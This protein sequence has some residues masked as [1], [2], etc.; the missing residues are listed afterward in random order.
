VIGAKKVTAPDGTVWRVGRQWVPTKPT[1]WRPKKRQK[2]PADKRSGGGGG[3]DLFPVG[4][5]SFDEG[6]L[7]VLALIA[8]VIVVILL[9]TVVFPIIVLG[10][11]L[12]IVIVLLVGGI[13]ARLVFRK[14]WTIRARAQD[15]REL[16]WR[17][18]GFQRSGRVRDDAAAALALGQTEVHPSEAA[19]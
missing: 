17:A 7:I 13:A 15:G 12:L 11:E 1:L 3:G 16:T 19:P 4:L 10:V 6:F 2:K 5:D 14:P 18:P 8:V 9:V